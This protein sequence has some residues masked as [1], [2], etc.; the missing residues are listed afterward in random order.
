[1]TAQQTI[2]GVSCSTGDGNSPAHLEAARSLAQ[3]MHAK[4]IRLI[5]GAD[6]SGILGELVRT[7]TSE[8]A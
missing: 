3:A 2:V 5:Y 7:R 8:R 1:M 4:S 6:T